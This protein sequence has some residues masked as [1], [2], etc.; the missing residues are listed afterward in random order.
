VFVEGA[1]AFSGEGLEDD[2]VVEELWFGV[3]LA[4]ADSEVDDG[5]PNGAVIPK[6]S[7]APSQ[8]ELVSRGV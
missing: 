8:S 7:P 3:E 5:R 6:V 2:P 1:E 4:P